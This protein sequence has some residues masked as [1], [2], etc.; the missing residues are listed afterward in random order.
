VFVAQ[1][2]VQSEARQAAEDETEEAGS[3]SESDND[4]ANKEESVTQLW[5]QGFRE[6][7]AANDRA[8][9]YDLEAQFEAMENE[10]GSLAQQLTSLTEEVSVGKDRFLHLNANFD[11]YR[12][13]AEWHRLSM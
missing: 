3:T 9:I 12:K 5:L 6:A 2:S 13:W 7:L 8:A 1:K 10:R 4:V 11:N